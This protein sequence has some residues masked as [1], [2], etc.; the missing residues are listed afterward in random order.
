MKRQDDAMMMAA[1]RRGAQWVC[2]RADAD[3]RDILYAEWL[4]P[5]LWSATEDSLVQSGMCGAEFRAEC[6]SSGG[7]SANCLIY[8]HHLKS[9]TAPIC[10]GA[11]ARV[12][13]I[14]GNFCVCVCVHDVLFLR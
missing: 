2:W 1:M 3:G 7:G 13:T 10:S 8:W 14:S 12:D 4:G 9:I 11:R 6:T 5:D